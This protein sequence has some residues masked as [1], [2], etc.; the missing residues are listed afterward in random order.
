MHTILDITQTHKFQLACFKIHHFLK[1]LYSNIL[2]IDEFIYRL[3]II[4]L[5]LFYLYDMLIHIC[6]HENFPILLY[7]INDTCGLIHLFSAKNKR[8]N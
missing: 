1:D 7:K 2:F 3:K 8:N 4:N 6:E 5:L